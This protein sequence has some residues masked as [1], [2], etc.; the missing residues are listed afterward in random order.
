MKSEM[1]KALKASETLMVQRL[2]SDLNLAAIHRLK[3]DRLI[4]EWGKTKI[5][6]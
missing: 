4:W 6:L 5:I 3:E 1:E 2:M